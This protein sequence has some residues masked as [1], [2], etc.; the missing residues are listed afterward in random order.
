M[1][2]T[3]ADASVYVEYNDVVVFPA[4]HVLQSSA[5]ATMVTFNIFAIAEVVGEVEKK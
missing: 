3:S 5:A 2:L 4:A 1:V